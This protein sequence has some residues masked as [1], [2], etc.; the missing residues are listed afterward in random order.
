MQTVGVR[1]ARGPDPLV[2][3]FVTIGEVVEAMRLVDH[4][5]H[6][7]TRNDLT[8]P[9]LESRLTESQWS[10]PA[11]TSG[12]D[13]PLGL[14]VRQRCAPLLDL[15]EHADPDA[16][17]ARRGELGA[18]EV[19]RRLLRAAGLAH[20]MVDTGYAADAL[21]DPAGMADAAG[22]RADEVVRLE[23]VA[24]QLA[25]EGVSATG[26][27]SAY[28]E[29][30][31]DRTTA[32]IAVKS[33]LAYRH[34]LDIDGDRPGERDVADAAGRWLRAT[35]TTGVAR[36]D[37]PVLLRHLLWAGIDR[38]LPVQL[39]TGFGDPDLDLHRSDPSLLTPF[40]RAARASHVP[41]MLLHCYPYH[42]NAA[43]L[44]HA[45]PDVYVDVG[46]A[47][48]HT[49]AGSTAAVA[50]LLELAPF[51]K[52]LFSSDGFGPAELH[53]LGSR[54]WRTALTKLLGR[55]VDDGDWSITYAERVA[56]MIGAD[57]ARRVY[58]L[59]PDDVAGPG[60]QGEG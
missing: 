18:G 50:E 20:V 44:A 5:A 31:A 36:V 35:E 38:G 25:V 30:L 51:G 40:L 60:R 42:R 29:R 32:A 52:V 10:P 43:Y 54:L 6:G 3:A 21:L 11:G 33:V 28:A 26:F 55:R 46:L 23:Q 4:H 58:G 49:G 56:R 7:A 27:V 13:S 19:N 14:A 37:D 9:E 16:Y 57:N 15:A 41:V 2:W 34:G 48:G 22:A 39:H 17:V 1:V 8:R 47:V 24:E 59:E 53:F 12:F 45:F